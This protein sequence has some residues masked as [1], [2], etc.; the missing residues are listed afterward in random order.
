[1]A[2]EEKRVDWNA[3]R[4]EYIAGGIGQRKLAKKH[5]IPEGTLIDKAHSE[6][7]AKLR[8]QANNKAITK[9]QQ[10][11]AESVASNAVIAQRIRAKLLAR[12]EK[13]IDALPESIGSNRRESGSSYEYGLNGKTL[14]S[15]RDL[16]R[17]YKLRDLTAA[18][19]DLT[20]GLIVPERPDGETSDGFLEALSQTAAEDWGG[21]DEG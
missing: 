1:M 7:W 20:D 17:E 6:Q 21:D 5:G 4:A 9:S 10:K 13:E 8:E 3:V 16:D 11:V 19:R 2:E 18:W 15:R 12:L 14:K